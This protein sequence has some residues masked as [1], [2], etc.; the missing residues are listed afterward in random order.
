[1]RALCIGRHPYLS[2]HYA[3]F[4]AG[5][6]LDT[7]AVVGFDDVAR[8]ATD[9]RPGLVLCDYDLLATRPLATWEC[10]P[11]LGHV[12]IIAVS[13]TRG[14]HEMLFQDVNGIA[15]CL[16]L[17]TLQREDTRRV[18]GAACPPPEYTLPSPFLTAAKPANQMMG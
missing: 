9:V 3:R 1:M 7:T 8:V 12:P 2:E 5:L 13:L 4:F 18:L 14:A 10:H 11:I 17:P 6:G 16:Y 15:G